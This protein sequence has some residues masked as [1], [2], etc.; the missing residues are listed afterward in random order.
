MKMECLCGYEGDDFIDV[1]ENSELNAIYSCTDDIKIYQCPKCGK[2]D[3]VCDNQQK[4]EKSGG[5]KTN[6]I[7]SE[8]S[9][10][11]NELLMKIKSVEETIQ[12]GD[13][14]ASSFADCTV[15]KVWEAKR[16]ALVSRVNELKLELQKLGYEE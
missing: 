3:V 8:Q 9:K 6:S 15:D 1:T 11:I 14:T 12:F 5:G 7:N 16:P 4:A 13:D 10:K 2:E